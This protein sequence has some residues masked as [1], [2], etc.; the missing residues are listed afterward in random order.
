MKT[1]LAFATCLALGALTA[2][3]GDEHH[4]GVESCQAIIDVCHEVDPGSG[5]INECH[6]TAHDE[7]TAE[8]CDPIEAECVSLCEAA[9]SADGGLGDGGH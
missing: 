2:C 4:A 3:D 5:R 7:G 9:A 6:E 1:F 8:A